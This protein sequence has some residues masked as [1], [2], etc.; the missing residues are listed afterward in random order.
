MFASQAGTGMYDGCRDVASRC[1]I[2]LSA[3]KWTCAGIA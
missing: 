3:T 1:R 2:A